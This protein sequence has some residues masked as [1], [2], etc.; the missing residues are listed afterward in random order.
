MENGLDG[1]IRRQQR[2][3]L[4]KLK[5]IADD[6]FIS[7]LMVKFL[8]DRVENIVEKGKCWLPQCFEKIFTWRAWNIIIVW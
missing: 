5:A 6:N 1:F 4:S 3:T 7:A 8:R 2:V